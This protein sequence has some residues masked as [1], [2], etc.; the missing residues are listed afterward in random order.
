MR[1][2]F[3][4][5]A[6]TFI[7]YKMR[8]SCLGRGRLYPHRTLFGR[9]KCHGGS[10]HDS[11]D[12]VVRL[13]FPGRG[14]KSNLGNL[15]FLLLDVGFQKVI[16]ENSA[17]LEE[18]HVNLQCPNRGSKRL[19]HALHVLRLFVRSLVQ[20]DVRGHSWVSLVLDAVD[21]SLHHSGEGDVWVA[22]GVWG[23]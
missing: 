16:G 7:L 19:R 14:S 15:H 8:G 18:V 2:E 4:A 13:E 23:P 3:E 12:V 11:L 6:Q 22:H 21:T 20:V 10:C 5:M 17:G 9:V 1:S